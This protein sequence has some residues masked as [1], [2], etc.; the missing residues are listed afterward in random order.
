MEQWHT[1]KLG[2]C[3]FANRGLK[4]VHF[5]SDDDLMFRCSSSSNE[6]GP[7]SLVEKAGP[8]EKLFFEGSL[9]E[10]TVGTRTKFLCVGL[11]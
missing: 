5:V 3:K 9:P 10:F 7:N 4:G 2:E 1:Q 11:L 8:R 6:H